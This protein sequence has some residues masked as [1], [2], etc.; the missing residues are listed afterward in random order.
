MKPGLE[1]IKI[2]SKDQNSCKIFE[3]TGKTK[4][5]YQPD[6]EEKRFEK[7]F[8]ITCYAPYLGDVQIEVAPKDSLGITEMND[9]VVP[10][11]TPFSLKQVSPFRWGIASAISLDRQTVWDT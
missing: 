10:Y 11:N 1:N 4:E 9:I 6:P 2:V 5:F 3:V 7:I 8:T